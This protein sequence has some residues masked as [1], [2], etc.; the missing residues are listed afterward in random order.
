MLLW[1]RHLAVIKITI[2]RNKG[3][4]SNTMRE[5]LDEIDF[6]KVIILYLLL[7]TLHQRKNIWIQANMVHISSIGLLLI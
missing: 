6:N 5:K 1:S 4:N 3:S 2:L 7:L